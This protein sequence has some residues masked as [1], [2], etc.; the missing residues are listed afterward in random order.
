M[1]RLQIQPN[2][3]ISPSQQLLAQ[4]Q[5]AIA[6]RYYTPGQRLPSTRQLAQQLNIHRN[7]VSRVYQLLETQG[8]VE[9]KKGSGIYVKTPEK[10]LNY[11][12]QSISATID[13]LLNEGFNLTQI[14]EIF[15]QEINYRLAVRQKI[16]VTTPQ[17]DLDTGDLMSQ[18]LTLALNRKIDLISLEK[19]KKYLRNNQVITVITNRF[20]AQKVSEVI[21]NSTTNLFIIDIYDYQQELQLIKELPAGIYLGLVSLSKKILTQAEKI[22]KSSRGEEIIIITAQSKERE[23]LTRLVKSSQIIISDRF[24]RQDLESVLG[25]IREE[26]RSFPRII[27][28]ENYISQ[29]SLQLLQK[30][31]PPQLNT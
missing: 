15:K 28:I 1:F 22:I 29:H 18:E 13:N 5:F 23:K 24:S 27:L 4:I 7:T 25:I 17:E 9:F 16:I 19:L 21:N 30:L 3:E 26:L 14:Q 6:S 8:L 10:P 12:N 11:V 31:F 2:S 20:F